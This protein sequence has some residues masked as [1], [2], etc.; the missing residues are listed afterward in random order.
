MATILDSIYSI[1]IR[2]FGFG[3]KVASLFGSKARSRAQHQNNWKTISQNRDLDK[4]LVW[5]H[6][7]SLGEFEQGRPLIEG[8][9]KKYPNYQILLTFF[10]PSGYEVR[11]D[12]QEADMVCYL[13]L[14]LAH[15]VNDFLDVLK[16]DIAFF[17]KYEFWR[18][19][20]LGLKLRSIPIISISAIFREDQLY[21]KPW[22]SF[23]RKPLLAIDYFF[24]QN[25][26]SAQLLELIGLGNYNVAGDTRF[27]RVADA[28]KNIKEI[29]S[30][31]K[32]KSDSK[33]MV[34]GS[35]WEEDMQVIIPL[36]NTSV[37]LKFIIAPHEIKEKQISDWESRMA[38][39]SVI[40]FSKIGGETDLASYD[41]LIIDNI[42]ILSS[43]YQYGDFAFIGG[44]FAT[45]LHNILEAATFGMPI[46]FGFKA[47]HK[48]QEAHDL[49]QEKGAFA[50]RDTKQVE[51]VMEQLL[52]D[53]KLYQSTKNTTAQ[54]VK[55]H[56]GATDVILEW[57]E[58]QV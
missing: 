51:K 43:L 40:R 16:P 50:V 12:Y 18:N 6:C 53:N 35:V 4:K 39:K 27:D 56:T 34:C 54:Y 38:G 41:I 49:I 42:G 29:S 48:F 57:L 36:I 47:Y 32:F 19:F 2:V 52:A 20:I 17:V 3:L 46:F 22:G 31:T 1:F 28:L 13:P 10:S 26:L 24:V 11:K 33:L 25:E 5:F 7:A 45:G 44:G 30:A 8:F 55:N 9:K 58:I 23:I 14:D 15:N 21:F 37:D